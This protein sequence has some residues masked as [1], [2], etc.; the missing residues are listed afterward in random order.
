MYAWQPRASLV[1]QRGNNEV[2]QKQKQVQM[3]QASKE[4]SGKRAGS[5][6]M[7]AQGYGRGENGVGAS[8]GAWYAAH[9][10]LK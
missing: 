5:S 1:Y 3:R 9:L 6:S 4:D 10:Q 8:V 2:A 7:E